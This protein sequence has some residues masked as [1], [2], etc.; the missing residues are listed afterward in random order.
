MPNETEQLGQFEASD[1]MAES[2][3]SEELYS[4]APRH[5]S[6]VEVAE[7]VESPEVKPQEQKTEVA[8]EVKPTETAP[9][10]KVTD[11]DINKYVKETFGFD[12]A[13][14]AKEQV[15]KWRKAEKEP[16]PKAEPEKPKFANEESEVLYNALLTGDKKKATELLKKQE[17]IEDAANLSP[18]E[19]I[20]LDLQYKNQKYTK[21][22]IEDIIEEK[23]S[24]PRKPSQRDDE[25]DDEFAERESAYNKEVAKIDRRIKRDGVEA[26]ENLQK[27]KTDL[28]L[29]DI[30][31]SKANYE[32]WLQQQKDLQ[33]EESQ[34][35]QAYLEAL[36]K[37]YSN[38]KGFSTTYK[39]KEVEVPIE[40][41]PTEQELKELKDTFANDFNEDEFF[42]NRWI[43]TEN[44]KVVGFNVA[45]QM[46]DKYLLENKQKVFDKIAQDSA[47]RA[48]AAY[49][50]GEKNINFG[51]SKDKIQAEN[52]QRALD[53]RLTSKLWGD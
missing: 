27:H 39:D 10:T 34:S 45:L 9:E 52:V 32:K 50:K 5:Q 47:A 26:V 24:Y 3:F 23:Y 44:D 53:E 48:I 35:H 19:Q 4:T 22:D 25:L 1:K 18:L 15:E 41:K 29:P 40:F 33:A 14:V 11:F 12:S 46:E 2:L 21:E 28:V 37:D 30:T 31:G 17:Q 13:E 51:S 16:K 8:A 6:G 49:L 38:F 20:K 36:E 42:A 7:K 43:K